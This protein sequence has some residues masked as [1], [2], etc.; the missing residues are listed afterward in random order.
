MLHI[1]TSHQEQGPI[2]AFVRPPLLFRLDPNFVYLATH[3]DPT[4]RPLSYTKL[5]SSVIKYLSNCS[6]RF[7]LF[8][9][10]L[11][12]PYLRTSQP[13]HFL[14]NCNNI[15]AATAPP[16]S[17]SV[18][19]SPNGNGFSPQLVTTT[20][21]HQTRTITF[22]TE[23]QTKPYSRFERKDNAIPKSP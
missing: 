15:E 9:T 11:S 18:E 14:S 19:I 20:E 3:L 6:P 8:L 13:V 22:S 16:F 1:T 5:S 17:S 12:E 7:L 4:D 2:I 21:Y 10:L 23:I